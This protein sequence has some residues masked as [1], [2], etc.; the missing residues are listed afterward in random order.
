MQAGYSLLCSQN[1]GPFASYIGR[2]YNKASIW[3]V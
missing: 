3:Q 2:L 1:G